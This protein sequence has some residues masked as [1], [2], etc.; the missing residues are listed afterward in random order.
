MRYKWRVALPLGLFAA[1]IT[2]WSFCTRPTAFTRAEPN[3]YC[4][5]FIVREVGG[6]TQVPEDV[7]FSPGKGAYVVVEFTP[8]A[9]HPTSI[10]GFVVENPLFWKC[11]VKV[12]VLANWPSNDQV[13]YV[14]CPPFK[15]DHAIALENASGEDLKRH[16]NIFCVVGSTDLWTAASGFKGEPQ[17]ELVL[18]HDRHRRWTL[19]AAPLHATAG[20]QFVYE[21]ILLPHAHA[22]SALRIAQ[23]PPVV[24]RRGLITVK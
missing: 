13:R 18:E 10:E 19:L 1:T 17:D 3:R 20:D 9:E 5:D 2:L 11:I 6:A 12:Y 14:D 21:I 4:K 23:G 15:D 7:Q 8:E 16:G 24:L 22:I